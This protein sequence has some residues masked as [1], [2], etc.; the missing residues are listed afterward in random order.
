MLYQTNRIADELLFECVNLGQVWGSGKGEF[1]FKSSEGLAMDTIS[2][3]KQILEFRG[4]VDGEKLPK[5]PYL[6]IMRNE[7]EMTSL[8]G[9][10][11]VY[12]NPT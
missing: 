7:M 8:L 11:D 9:G 6:R 12:L 5:M 3:I 4:K 2:T 10:L 1:Q